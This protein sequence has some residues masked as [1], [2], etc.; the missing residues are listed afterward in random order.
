MFLGEEKLIMLPVSRRDSKI[1]TTKVIQLELP[2]L[3][4]AEPISTLQ[5]NEVKC[6]FFYDIFELA[7]RVHIHPEQVANGS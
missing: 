3:G 1:S 6:C 2:K 4:C 5:D 7:R